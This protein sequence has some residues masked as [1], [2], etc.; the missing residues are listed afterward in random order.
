MLL[1]LSLLFPSLFGQLIPATDDLVTLSLTACASGEVDTDDLEDG[2]FVDLTSSLA[3]CFAAESEGMLELSGRGSVVL[4]G[5]TTTKELGLVSQT[6]LYVRGTNDYLTNLTSGYGFGSLSFEDGASLSVKAGG[7]IGVGY[8]IYAQSMSGSATLGASTNHVT[9]GDVGISRRNSTSTMSLTVQGADIDA[10][11]QVYCSADVVFEGPTNTTRTYPT[12]QSVSL[13]DDVSVTFR[14]E[15]FGLGD[16]EGEGTVVLETSAGHAVVASDAKMEV[17]RLTVTGGAHVEA[18][19][20]AAFSADL[21]VDAGSTLDIAGHATASSFTTASSTMRVAIEADA[22]FRGAL[23]VDGS[24]TV[25]TTTFI[26][27]GALPDRVVL[28]DCSGGLTVEG[29]LSLKVGAEAS[30]SGKRQSDEDEEDEYEV[31]KDGRKI[32]VVKVEEE[33]DSATTASLSALIGAVA[34]AVGATA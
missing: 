2:V 23:E 20:G 13:S 1:L 3:V 17:T 19:S 8:N 28:L 34:V 16:I 5:G 31:K 11:Y 32:V 4:T 29:S 6:N 21:F 24:C 14:D 18:E 10:G 12:S 27:P 15:V 7:T 33:P 26:V 30:V 9:L 22:D 25:G